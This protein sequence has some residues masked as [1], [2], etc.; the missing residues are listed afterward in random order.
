M[1]QCIP[2]KK[3]AMLAP[4]AT[5]RRA[6]FWRSSAGMNGRLAATGGDNVMNGITP[7]YTTLHPNTLAKYTTKC[8]TVK[9][10]SNWVQQLY[11]LLF[12][13]DFS[14]SM[15]LRT[16]CKADNKVHLLSPTTW[17]QLVHLTKL[18]Q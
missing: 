13:F 11:N 15:S 3:D 5:C 17:R 16:I 14:R 9:Q 1:A 4:Y 18:L 7:A 6:A 12:G 10:K 8:Q 2:P